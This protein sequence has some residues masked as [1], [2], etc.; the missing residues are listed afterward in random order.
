MTS[1]YET[2]KC[3]KPLCF[4]QRKSMV[5]SL[6]MRT[7]QLH[8]TPLLQKQILWLVLSFQTKFYTMQHE[9]P[10]YLWS[11]FMLIFIISEIRLFFYERCA[12]G[13]TCRQAFLPNFRMTLAHA[14]ISQVNVHSHYQCVQGS[15]IV[16]LITPTAFELWHKWDP[17]KYLGTRVHYYM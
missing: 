10:G 5:T 3:D 14:F 11:H 2:L 7:I 8:W 1:W 13:F 15:R 16:Y 9:K 12:I 4:L 6:L 17:C